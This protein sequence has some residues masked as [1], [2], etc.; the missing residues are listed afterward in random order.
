MQE[1]TERCER[2]E[3]RFIFNTFNSIKIG[4]VWSNWQSRIVPVVEVLVLLELWLHAHRPLIYSLNCLAA[5]KNLNWH[6]SFQLLKASGRYILW[7][8][9]SFVEKHAS[10]LPLQISKQGHTLAPLHYLRATNL[11]LKL[12]R[13][14]IDLWVYISLFSVVRS[15]RRHLHSDFYW[16]AWY[17]LV[18]ADA[19]RISGKRWLSWKL[20]TGR[21][22]WGPRH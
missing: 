17:F 16:T 2:K 15:C 10:S 12:G 5:I 1:S 3:N 20:S 7:S 11:L 9:W 22:S 21:R 8:V 4:K 13:S 18:H 19:D 6:G 14:V